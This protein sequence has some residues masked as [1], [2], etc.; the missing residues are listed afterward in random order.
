VIWIDSSFAVEWLGG[1][2]R[3]AEINVDV[4]SGVQILPMQYAAMI[5]VAAREQR[6]KASL[7]DAVLAATVRHRGGVLY[8]F[9]EDFRS[10]GMRREAPARWVRA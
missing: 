6:S 10:L 4:E 3:A 8:T 1:T 7:A 2:R 9:D 5:Y